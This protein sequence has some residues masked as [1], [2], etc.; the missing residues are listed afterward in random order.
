MLLFL[1]VAVTF[2]A[3]MTSSMNSHRGNGADSNECVLDL[4]MS[5]DPERSM[6][7]IKYLASALN[8]C[9]FVPELPKMK[10]RYLENTTVTCN[11]GS[12]A[13]YY[14]YPSNGSTRW[15]I[16]LEGGWYCF[17]DDSCQSRWESMR[18]LMSSTRWTP[19]KAG[20]GLLSPDPEENPNWWNANKV[21]I[22]YC[23]SDV[24]SGTARAD[25]GG[26][27]FMGA[28]ILQEV[29]RELIPQGLLVANKILLAGS[30]AGG[31]GVLLNLDYVS[32]ML[33]AAGSNA[34]VR[35]ICDSGW[36][37]DTVQHRAQPCTN[38]LSCAP[39]EVIKRGIKLW[40]GQ[41]PARCSEEYSYNDQWKCFFGY[42]IYPTLQT[43]V[44][45][46]QWLYDEAQLV[47]GMTGPPAKLEHWNYMQ[48]LGRELRH[49]LKNVS[50]VFAPACYSHKVIDKMQ[51]LNVHVKGISLPNA[52][53]CWL[54]SN[55][56]SNHSLRNN[57]DAAPEDSDDRQMIV[58]PASTQGRK[59]RQES[60]EYETHA[61]TV[62]Q[63]RCHHHVI[64][65]APCPQC[66]PM[67]PKLV[68]PFTD[69]EMEFLPFLKLM[70]FDLSGLAKLL[71]LDAQT[72]A[73]MME[74]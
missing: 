35:G 17:D 4:Q 29:I 31:T 59:Q 10:L 21:F 54:N 67:C 42:R 22:P 65:N 20:S 41:V 70:G 34:V 60:D 74:G 47:V 43:P 56:E 68:N 62:H 45:I 69:E 44:F 66:N 7:Q 8:L 71:G 24:W 18:G 37:L 50:A 39:S 73:M 58:H 27:A 49:S 32:D 57:E 30:S 11:D 12:P 5:D 25:Q 14:L 53:E 64:D 19:E 33:S 9:G 48:Q 72:M 40:S 63:S 52:L 46:F 55:E 1:V 38:T 28:L 26:Y 6:T 16:F 15:L 3:K 61:H 51:W 23:S 2:C 13:G 36:F